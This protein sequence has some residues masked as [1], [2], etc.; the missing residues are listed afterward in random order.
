MSNCKSFLIDNFL[1]MSRKWN[2]SLIA[3]I[4]RF[5]PKSLI[6]KMAFPYIAAAGPMFPFSTDRQKTEE[7]ALNLFST[8]S[9]QISNAKSKLI[10]LSFIL[11][12]NKTI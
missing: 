8:M 6:V 12:E 3:P 7:R 2:L 11:D 4:H 9:L 1:N 5:K 10:D